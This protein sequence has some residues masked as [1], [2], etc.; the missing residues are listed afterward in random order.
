[1]S[2][3]FCGVFGDFRDKKNPREEIENR[4]ADCVNAKSPTPVG[5]EA[6]VGLCAISAVTSSRRSIFNPREGIETLI[7]QQ[8]W[9]GLLFAKLR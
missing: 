9:A 1:L 8:P 6:G 7:A 3:G 5:C 4:A 2:I